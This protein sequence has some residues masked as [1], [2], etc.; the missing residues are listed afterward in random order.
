MSE[1]RPLRVLHV[2]KASGVGGSER[3]LAMLLPAL[4]RAGV[5]VRMIAA[6]TGDGDRFARELE[7]LGVDVRTIP[8]GPDVNP[9]LVRRIAREI[10]AFRPGLV[11]THLVHADVHGQIAA[12]LRGVTAVSSV[13]G[14]LAA[15]RRAP[16]R[17]AAGAIGR[18]PALTIAISH[19]VREFLES[20]R[21]RPA[22]RVRVVHYGIEADRW[23]TADG[24]R[25]RLRS[26]LGIGP[27]D[28]TIAVTSRLIPGKGHD[29]L[30]NAFAEASR[31]A[32]ELRLAIA[33]DGPERAS[34]EARA[35][36]IDGVRFLGFVDD[37]RPL[38]K[39]A[40][41]LAF[42]TAPELG[43]GFGL[44]ALEAMAASRP[45]VATA[46]GAIP[47]VVDDGVTGA[48]VAPRDTAGL[49]DALVR[50]AR[51]PEERL[52]L[53]RRGAERARREFG[54][55]ALVRGTLDVYAEARR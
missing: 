27:G 2:Q 12:R 16:L 8:A 5:E 51:E 28:V 10:A 18:L 6:V 31:R 1:A 20:H 41:A 36:G 21:L 11:H 26:E 38:V 35:E 34:L 23:S 44:T 54:L 49:A 42:P 47:E 3:H 22:G 17:P 19:H 50:V 24:E 55:A 25:G 30:L 39:A 7:K 40:D 45:V 14:T 37:V 29:L 53:G 33:G 13:H 52:A 46:V 48:L 4:A 15:L 32:P 9:L 43:E